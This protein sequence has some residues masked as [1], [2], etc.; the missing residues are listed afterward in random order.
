VNR[1]KLL[2]MMLI[3]SV[4]WACIGIFTAKIILWMGLGQIILCGIFI[5]WVLFCGAINHLKNIIAEWKG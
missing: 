3:L 1:L 2:I 4:L 5:G